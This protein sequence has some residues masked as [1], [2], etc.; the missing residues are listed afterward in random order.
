MCRAKGK[1]RDGEGADRARESVGLKKT[2]STCMFR[3]EAGVGF[4]CKAC[5]WGVVKLRIAASEEAGKIRH[6]R[7]SLAK[8]AVNPNAH[9]LGRESHP[10]YYNR[11]GRRLAPISFALARSRGEA[12]SDAKPRG[13]EMMS[14]HASPE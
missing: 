4:T 8:G 11:R 10:V 6:K 14:R 1:G 7:T 9:V 5:C 3:A 12:R 13:T 2:D